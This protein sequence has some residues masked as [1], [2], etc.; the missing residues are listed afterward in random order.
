MAGEGVK[1]PIEFD[2]EKARRTI[3]D[4]YGDLAGLS[5]A[6]GIGVGGVAVGTFLGQQAS[7]AFGAVARSAPVRGLYES[8]RDEVLYGLAPEQAGAIQ[9]RLSTRDALTSK[10]GRL[11]GMGLVSE[12]FLRTQ[13]AWEE[14]YGAGAQARGEKMI[15]GV[16]GGENVQEIAEIMGKALG[17]AVKNAIPVAIQ[18]IKGTGMG[19]G[20]LFK[21][22]MP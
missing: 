21:G 20:A 17:E 6:G 10:Y 7:N 1:I 4:L 18:A 9:G 13:A 12:D 15:R 8:M 14:Q 2:A 11:A 19:I 22:L 3:R 16:I 5:R